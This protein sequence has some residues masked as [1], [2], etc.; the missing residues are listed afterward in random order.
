M[1]R[2]EV[3]VSS[4]DDLVAALDEPDGPTSVSSVR[5]PQSLRRA[6]AAAVEL[7]W[8]SSANEAQNA[9]LRGYLEALAQRAAL[10][11]HYAAHPRSRPDLAEVACA[12]AELDHH[13]LA[14]HPDLIRQAARE[15]VIDRP[16]AD[17][18]DVLLWAA[19]LRHHAGSGPTR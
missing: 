13:P 6:V 11:A 17:A 16:D 10:D 15:V 8:V 12:L 1:P 9:G 14:A 19:S 3:A 18:D 2:W 7:G 5:Q 4:L